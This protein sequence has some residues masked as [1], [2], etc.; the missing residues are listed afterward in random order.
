MSQPPKSAFTILI[1]S[2]AI[3]LAGLNA[4]AGSKSS[5]SMSSSGSASESKNQ[6]VDEARRS[7][8]ETELKAHQMREEK[9][10]KNPSN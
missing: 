6:K 4:C 2:L 9:S 10:R 5:S 7:A 8:E 3:T 1:L